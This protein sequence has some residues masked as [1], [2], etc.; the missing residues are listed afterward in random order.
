MFLVKF[1]LTK[2][3]LHMYI[4]QVCTHFSPLY[5]LRGEWRMSVGLV[6]EELCWEP[7]MLLDVE[8]VR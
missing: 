1:K 6:E 2:K 4:I 8:A 5:F 3:N 7:Q